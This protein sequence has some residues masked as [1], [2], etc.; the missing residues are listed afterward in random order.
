MAWHLSF[1]VQS[2]IQ[3][4]GTK[5]ALIPQVNYREVCVCVCVCV[6]VFNGQTRLVVNVF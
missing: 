6:C 2:M 5:Q 1:V 3:I 4:N